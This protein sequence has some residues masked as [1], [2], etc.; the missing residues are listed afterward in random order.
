MPLNFVHNS[1]NNDSVQNNT[2]QFCVIKTIIQIN[3]IYENIY[4][5]KLVPQTVWHM[6]NCFHDLWQALSFTNLPWKLRLKMISAIVIQFRCSELKITLIELL[7]IINYYATLFA[8]R[9]AESL[10]IMYLF[11]LAVIVSVI[12]ILWNQINDVLLEE[13]QV[14]SYFFVS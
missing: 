2:I 7:I 13:P 1:S 9:N 14:I 8:G 11:N 5:F 12:I 6:I 4:H 3:R 10:I